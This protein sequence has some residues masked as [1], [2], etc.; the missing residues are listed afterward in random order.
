MNFAQTPSLRRRATQ[1]G[2]S[3]LIG[4]IVLTVLSLL[5]LSAIRANTSNLRIVGNQQVIDESVAAAQQTIE[6]V[7]SHN[8]TVAPVAVARNVDVNADAKADY[9]VTVAKPTCKANTPIYNDFPNILPECLASGAMAITG[10]VSEAGTPVSHA[11]SWCSL[12]AWELQGDVEAAAGA[13]AM[14]ANVR[15]R[16]NQGVSLFVPA[17]TNC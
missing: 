17:G 11:Q 7:I 15:T 1:R 16:V 14:A 8:F 12:Q 10:Q 9:V 6:E 13:D 5:I 4:L 2:F 3:L